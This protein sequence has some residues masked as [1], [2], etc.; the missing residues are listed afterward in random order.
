MKELNLK[1]NLKESKKG[2]LKGVTLLFVTYL[3][4]YGIGGEEIYAYEILKLADVNVLIK[5]LIVFGIAGYIEIFFELLLQNISKKKIRQKEEKKAI[6]L[7]MKQNFKYMFLEAICILVIILIPISLVDIINKNDIYM[8]AIS[9][10]TWMFYIIIRMFCVSIK[11]G[12]E[13]IKI[14]KKI[15]EFNK[16]ID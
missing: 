1:E 12:M 2:I 13:E 7:N 15:K 4:L 8:E 6:A 3:L 5:Q 10:I 9:V 16:N 11:N 14:N